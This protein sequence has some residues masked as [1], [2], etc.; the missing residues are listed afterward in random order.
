MKGHFRPKIVKE[1]NSLSTMFMLI[2]SGM[3]ISIHFLL[4]KDSCN[5]DL[6]FIPLDLGDNME[7]AAD[8]GAALVWKKGSSSLALQAFI[9]CSQ[10]CS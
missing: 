9:D 10:V 7:D 1:T 4:H 3:G 2:A 8:E 6:R 5:Y